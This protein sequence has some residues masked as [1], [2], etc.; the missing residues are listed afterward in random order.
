MRAAYY[1][2]F[3]LILFINKISLFKNY[4]GVDKAV[5]KTDMRVLF[6]TI[7]FLGMLGGIVQ[8]WPVL[9]DLFQRKCCDKGCRF[10]IMQTR[11]SSNG[12]R[13]ADEGQKVSDVRQICD[14]KQRCLVF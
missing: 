12:K 3:H 6:T 10:C 14:K 1:H 11:L 5:L 7:F 9:V 13:I 2:L 4:V 8:M